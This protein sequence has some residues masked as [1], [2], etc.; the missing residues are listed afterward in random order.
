MTAVECSL[1]RFLNSYAPDR[2]EWED[3][4]YCPRAR[5]LWKGPLASFS[6]PCHGIDDYDYARDDSNA[7][8]HHLNVHSSFD[9]DNDPS[10]MS[11]SVSSGSLRSTSL[12]ESFAFDGNISVGDRLTDST[13]NEIESR[14]KFSYSFGDMHDVDGNACS[15]ILE[16]MTALFAEVAG[17]LMDCEASLDER[18]P[19][20]P[21]DFLGDFLTTAVSLDVYGCSGPESISPTVT[22]NI[23]GLHPPGLPF[24]A[25]RSLQPNA[26][27]VA[28][29]DTQ[30]EDVLAHEQVRTMN[31]MVTVFQF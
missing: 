6:P 23:S 10:D 14:M 8:F 9:D 4:D 31:L 18:R 5:F 15:K 13:L 17:S 29:P 16:W 20:I 12:G 21:C 2:F 11:I 19:A 24:A 22:V 28:M 27:L 30:N 26:S 3:P 1:S 7:I 25:P